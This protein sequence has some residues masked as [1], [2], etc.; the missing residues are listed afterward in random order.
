MTAVDNI[1]VWEKYSEAVNSRDNPSTVHSRFLLGCMLSGAIS[2]YA[3]LVVALAVAS[4]VTLST[5]GIGAVAGVGLVAGI[6][7]YGLFKAKEAP[8]TKTVAIEP[9]AERIEDIFQEHFKGLTD[10]ASANRMS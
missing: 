3:L 9:N 2:G 10:S 7:S 1:A 8:N 6:T 4:I 5:A